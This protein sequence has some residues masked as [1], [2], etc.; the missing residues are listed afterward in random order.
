LSAKHLCDDKADIERGDH[1]KWTD[2]LMNRPE[3]LEH[4]KEMKKFRDETKSF[5][6]IKC[7]NNFTEKS[8]KLW[9]NVARKIGESE[10]ISEYLDASGIKK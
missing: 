7:H 4:N 9:N 6:C 8:S 1:K 2:D 3:L 5:V 10:A